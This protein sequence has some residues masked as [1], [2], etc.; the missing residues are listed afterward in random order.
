[1]SETEASPETPGAPVER[2]EF[3]ELGEN[4]STEGGQDITEVQAGSADGDA[5]LVSGESGRLARG[6]GEEI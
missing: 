3:D 6:E 2:A 5:N 1:M 4:A